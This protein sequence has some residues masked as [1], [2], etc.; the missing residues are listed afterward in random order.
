M[1]SKQHRYENMPIDDRDDRSSTEVE[2][3]MEET[4][5]WHDVDLQRPVRRSRTSTICALLSSWRWLIDTTLLLIILGF[6]AKSYF[7]EQVAVKPYDFGG[8]ITGVG[9]KFSEQI[10]TFVH[11]EEYAPYNVS[12]F[13]KPDVL[14]K[15]NKL[16]PLGMGFQW[17]KEPSK[18]HDL[19]NPIDWDPGMT[20]FTTSMTH[21]LHCLWAI[22]QTYS[23]LK[24]GHEIPD[25]HH[26]HMIHCFSY[27]RQA[28]LCAADTALE[29]HATTFPDDN[30][31]S[32][33]WDAKHV[34]KD[35]NQVRDYLES[36]R[37]YDD[38][39][40]Y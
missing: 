27:M 12:E 22:V 28:I 11:E 30:S 26:W 8:D 9:P 4:K 6:V 38:Q 33:G 15:W 10:T 31:G 18:Y 13:F 34:C 35:I 23:G 40:I 21:Q 3:L 16:M 2:S 14:E 25:D 29:G 1:G 37:A 17:V 39:Q 5:Q 7:R 32:D 36:V 19:P 20:V 24:S